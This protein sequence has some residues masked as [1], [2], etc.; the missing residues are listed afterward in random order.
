MN[1][2]LM[3]VGGTW[4]KVSMPRVYRS[5]RG[6]SGV[7]TCN[8]HHHLFLM[9][10]AANDLLIGKGV[11]IKYHVSIHNVSWGE[12][13]VVYASLTGPV[14]GVPDTYYPNIGHRS[15]VAEYTPTSSF[16]NGGSG[17]R[18]CFS[19]HICASITGSGNI[20]LRFY[21]EQ[22]GGTWEFRDDTLEQSTAIM[23]PLGG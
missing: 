18:S 5:D 2:N 17:R 3:H 13:R 11:M 20:Y 7:F 21:V 8:A 6:S 16:P 19:G 12:S 1:T 14:R 23:M 9:P 4:S 22:S 10:I 15:S